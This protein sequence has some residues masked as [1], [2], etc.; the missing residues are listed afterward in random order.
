MPPGK[1]ARVPGLRRQRRAVSA[2]KLTQNYLCDCVTID[3]MAVLDRT[4]LRMAAYELAHEPSVPVAV[5]ISEAVELAKQYSTEESGRFVNG[6][7]GQVMVVTPQIRAAAA[8]MRGT[9]DGT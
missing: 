6:V 1:A 9:S 5:V 4:L 2:I 3:R 8:A 7:L